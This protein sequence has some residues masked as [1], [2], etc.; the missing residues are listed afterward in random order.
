MNLLRKVLEML[1]TIC[2][3][4]LF[5]KFLIQMANAFLGWH[6]RWVFLEDI[7]HISSILLILIFVFAIPAEMLKEKERNK[8]Q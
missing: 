4:L 7:P 6:L 2:A 1:A 5:L 8:E 3:L